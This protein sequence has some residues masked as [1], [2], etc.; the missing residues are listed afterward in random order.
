LY[1]PNYVMNLSGFLMN[2][3]LRQLRAFIAVARCGSFTLA[4]EALHQTQS[5]L[6][7]QIKE[8]EQ[9]LGLRLFDRTTR[10]I[11]LSDAGQSLYPQIGKILHDLDGVLEEAGNLK[12]L[13]T[14]SLGIAAPQM[15]AATLL[16]RA[17]A[18]FTQR[19]PGIRLRLFDCEVDRIG[20]RVLAG[21]ADIGIGP[22]R[23]PGSDIVAETLFELPFV[24]VF[25][26]GHALE[27]SPVVH[28]SDLLAYPFISLQGEF[29]ERLVSELHEVL[30]A[31]LRTPD[32]EVAFMS[33]ALSMVEAGLGVTACLPYAA[34]AVRRHGLRMSRLIAPEVSRRF[35]LY[36][37]KDHA[38]SPAAEHFR[39]FLHEF[40]ADSALQPLP[41]PNA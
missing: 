1:K 13:R 17:M 26:P 15:M 41:N 39:A 22:A 27:A 25:P 33:T 18:A 2:I 9:T 19:W 6:S 35:C 21:E 40:L 11:R 38:L 10:S 24:A 31:A 8:L 30:H 5:A 12:S 32:S 23:K 14:G 36:T 16:P 20:A 37:R 7:G 28:W 4:A 29:T 3:S 34:P